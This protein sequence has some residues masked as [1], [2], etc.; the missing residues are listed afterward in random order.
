[1][2]YKAHQV[3]DIFKRTCVRLLLNNSFLDIILSGG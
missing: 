2:H 1:M 3:I